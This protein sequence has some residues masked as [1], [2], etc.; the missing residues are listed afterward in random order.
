LI[1]EETKRPLNFKVIRT[2]QEATS[3][4]MDKEKNLIIQYLQASIEARMGDKERA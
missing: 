4:L 1:G 3:E 2:S